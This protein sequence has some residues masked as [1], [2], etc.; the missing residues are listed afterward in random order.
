M[1]SKFFVTVLYHSHVSN[2]RIEV[3]VS[4]DN[5]LRR[6]TRHSVAQTVSCEQC[7]VNSVPQTKY[8]SVS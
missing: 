6:V 5:L 1:P 7:P 3:E 4:R 2:L 8:F